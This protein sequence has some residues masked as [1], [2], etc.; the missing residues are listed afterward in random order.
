MLI[1]VPLKEEFAMKL[2]FMCE[3]KPWVQKIIYQQV[4]ISNICQSFMKMMNAWRMKAFHA[5]KVKSK[6]WSSRNKMLVKI[7]GINV[8]TSESGAKAS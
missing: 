3:L 2:A 5:I 4:N 7:M 6:A 1:V 8:E